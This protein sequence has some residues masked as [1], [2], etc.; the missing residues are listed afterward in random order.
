MIKNLLVDQLSVH[1]DYDHPLGKAVIQIDRE[2]AVDLQ[3]Y[4]YPTQ[5]SIITE[6]GEIKPKN[7]GSLTQH[8][9]HTTRMIKN[10]LLNP[11]F[12]STP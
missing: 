6:L 4:F 5:T 11:K 10:A 3:C 7:A 2:A 12:T 1:T 8:D 9:I